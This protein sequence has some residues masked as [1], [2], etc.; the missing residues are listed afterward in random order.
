MFTP[1]LLHQSANMGSFLQLLIVLH[2]WA[3]HEVLGMF[4]MAALPSSQQQWLEKRNADLTML[5]LH[6]GSYAAFHR[7]PLY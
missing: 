4:G 7:G 5:V 1:H 2:V 3:A 6:A